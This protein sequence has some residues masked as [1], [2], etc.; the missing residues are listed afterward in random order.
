MGTELGLKATLH[1]RGSQNKDTDYSSIV[2][3]H[4]SV[5]IVSQNGCYNTDTAYVICTDSALYQT[6]VLW[7]WVYWQ[8]QLVQGVQT[9][10]TG[11]RQ[12]RVR[13]C[14]MNG[15]GRSVETL[16][17]HV[18]YS[19]LSTFCTIWH[20]TRYINLKEPSFPGAVYWTNEQ[21]QWNIGGLPA[22]HT[23][24]TLTEVLCS[25]IKFICHSK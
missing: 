10:Q 1:S 2:K 3:K 12:V 4:T 7:L 24:C 11:F 9:T 23:A 20:C 19:V 5:H 13:A 8:C 16:L 21:C 6:D 18:L 22:T 14:H 15:K 25:L 17:W